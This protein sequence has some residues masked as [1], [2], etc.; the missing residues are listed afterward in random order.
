MKS[1]IEKDSWNASSRE[2]SYVGEPLTVVGVCLDDES[3]RFLNLF[4]GLTP[5]VRVRSRVASYRSDQD[6]DANLEQLGQPAPDV[7]LMDFDKNRRAA[8]MMAER[9]HASLPG[10]AIFAV[11]SQSQPSAILE[12][13]RCGCS[14]YLTKPIDRDQ[15]T[16]AVIRIG[17]RLK[18]KQDQTH[19]QL[20]AFMGAKGGCGTTTLATQLGALLAG[21]FSRSALLLDLH[22]DFGDAALYLKLTKTRYHFFELLENTDRMDADFLESFLM[23]HSSGLELIPAP[24]GSVATRDTVPPGALANTLDFLRPRYEF[25]LVDLPPALNDENLAVVRD[26]DQL[27][28]VTVAEVSAVRNV[29]RQLE[30]FSSK[31]IPRDKIRV[32]VNRHHKRNVVTDAQIEKAI[33]QKIFWR[34]PNHYPQVV[35]TIHE[36]DP[37]AQLANSEVTRSLEQWAAEIGRKPGTETKK[38]GGILG[39]WNR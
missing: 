32:V 38:P 2:S 39:L 36:G 23:R 26:C 25:I 16:T 24:E 31:D 27:Y 10:T 6:Q 13:M 9:I 34:V 35:K 3:W 17:S 20:L 11:S 7:C 15:L 8:V 18:D 22:P 12:A 29:V 19:A 14:E 37:L 33:E 1:M 30:Y 28:L 4:A 5:S 21:S